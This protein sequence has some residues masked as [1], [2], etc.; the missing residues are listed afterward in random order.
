LP[1]YSKFAGSNSVKGDEFLRNIKISSTTSFGREIKPSVHVVSFYGILKNPTGMK[2]IFG[3]QNSAAI[4]CQVLPDSLLYFKSTLVD[5]SG[6]I[7]NKMG[8]H[9]R[10]E[11]VVVRRLPCAHP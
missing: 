10:S 4:P 6:M 11:M 9:D 8:A 3:R 7:S 1:L 2:E 5:E